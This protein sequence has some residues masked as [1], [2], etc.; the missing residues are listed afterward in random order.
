MKNKYVTEER[1]KITFLVRGNGLDKGLG[2]VTGTEAFYSVLI[3]CSSL[4]LLYVGVSFPIR[5]LKWR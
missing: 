1:D 5:K 3:L 4:S 2:R